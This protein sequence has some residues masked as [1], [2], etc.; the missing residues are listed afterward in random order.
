MYICF[1]RQNIQKKF[2]RTANNSK[3]E[4]SH[5]SGCKAASLGKFLLTFK[6]NTASLLKGY[7][8][9][10]PHLHFCENLKMFKSSTICITS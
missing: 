9:Q 1:Y 2:H 8:D 4:D 6:G 10:S 7:M 3:P 5:F